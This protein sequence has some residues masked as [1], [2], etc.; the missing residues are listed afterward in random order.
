MSWL[1]MRKVRVLGWLRVKQKEGN[2]A[3][4]G[5]STEVK[6]AMKKRGLVRVNVQQCVQLNVNVMLRSTLM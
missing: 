2:S 4:T 5:R 6:D 3:L 1:M